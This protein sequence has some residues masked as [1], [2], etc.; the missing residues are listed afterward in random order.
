MVPPVAAPKDRVFA[1]PLARAEAAAKI[2]AVL[3]VEAG[4]SE[5][6]VAHVHCSGSCDNAQN[7]AK[8]GW[9]C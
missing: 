9:M 4:E 3:G 7:R 6:M 2:A 1:S 8:Y 5:K